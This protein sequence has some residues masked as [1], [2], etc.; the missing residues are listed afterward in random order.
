MVLC[1]A[2]DAHRED[3]LAISKRCN[4]SR[5][6]AVV[7]SEQEFL[8]GIPRSTDEL[9]VRLQINILINSKSISSLL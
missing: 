3:I 5:W 8:Q 7:L 1:S 9:V 4:Q 2:R 6:K